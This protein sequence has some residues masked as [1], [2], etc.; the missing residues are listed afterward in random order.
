MRTLLSIHH[1]GH[2]CPSLKDTDI[3]FPAIQNGS[4][5]FEF[6]FKYLPVLL[7]NAI[8]KFPSVLSL[9]QKTAWIKIANNR[10][11]RVLKNIKK[12]DGQT[13]IDKYRLS[14]NLV[15]CYLA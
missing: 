7:L 6:E 12:S 10:V 13:N 1:N 3:K 11:Q 5:N 8:K 2:S 4:L 14:A 9:L 15:R